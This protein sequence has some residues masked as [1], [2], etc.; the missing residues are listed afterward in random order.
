MRRRFLK[1]TEMVK[2]SSH[3]YSSAHGCHVQGR[4]KRL[5]MPHA[6]SHFCIPSTT[7]AWRICRWSNLSSVRFVTLTT[8]STTFPRCKNHV[9][10][11]K[12]PFDHFHK[13]F[14]LST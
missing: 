4:G 11:R 1:E 6:R 12:D 7:P 2:P 10:P 5:Q 3:V 9:Q 13:S 14:A 8:T